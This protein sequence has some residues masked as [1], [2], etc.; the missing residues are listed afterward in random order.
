MLM[1]NS[2]PVIAACHNSKVIQKLLLS[3]VVAIL[4]LW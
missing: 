2:S 1:A 4:Y 3:R